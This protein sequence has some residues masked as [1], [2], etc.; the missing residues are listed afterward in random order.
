MKFAVKPEEDMSI[1]AS[2]TLLSDDGAGKIHRLIKDD[3]FSVLEFSDF[4]DDSTSIEKCVESGKP[5]IAYC[6]GTLGMVYFSQNDFYFEWY[7]RG[8]GG[9]NCYWY[10]EERFIGSAE[11]GTC[12][13]IPYDK[14]LEMHKWESEDLIVSNEDL[15]CLS[16]CRSEGAKWER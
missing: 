6:R 12:F 13:F 3:D 11:E 16:I 5:Y 7:M 10:D 15:R 4:R 9:G 8:D 1:F 2:F 14:V